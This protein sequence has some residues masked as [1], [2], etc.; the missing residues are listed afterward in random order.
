MLLDMRKVLRSILLVEKR[1]SGSVL[2]VAHE[3][4]QEHAASNNCR[5]VG[6]SR[7]LGEVGEQKR[8]VGMAQH[9]T[10]LFA[11]VVLGL[12]VL[13][14]VAIVDG[15]L[16]ARRLILKRLVSLSQLR[17]SVRR[18]GATNVMIVSGRTRG[19]NYMSSWLR[20]FSSSGS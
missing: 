17:R 16:G 20:T 19:V 13:L 10:R 9:L 2:L 11:V 1:D 3:D 14:P 4:I 6:M 5:N 12:I 7:A 18:R 15:S 8:P